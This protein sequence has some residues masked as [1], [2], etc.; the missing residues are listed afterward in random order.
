[1]VSRVRMML[2]IGNKKGGFTLIEAMITTAVLSL[3]ALLIHE[4]FFISLDAFNYCHN[5]LDIVSFA[6]EKIWQAQD[7]LTR[8]GA[9]TNI[10]E[11]GEL[12]MKNKNFEWILSNSPIMDTEN[13]NLYKID[14]SLSWREGRR[15]IKISRTA[16]AIYE[17]K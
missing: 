6:D 2:K 14:L 10:D 11:K 15:P 13:N 4:A 7:D 16:F 5:Y 8:F 1:M 9:L 3:T 12:T 17:K